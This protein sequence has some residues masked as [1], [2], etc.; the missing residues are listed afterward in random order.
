MSLMRIINT[1]EL[2]R[3]FVPKGVYVVINSAMKL[4]PIDGFDCICPISKN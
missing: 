3:C 2:S 1:K 4:K